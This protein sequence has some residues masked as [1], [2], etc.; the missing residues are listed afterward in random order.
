MHTLARCEQTPDG[1][2]SVRMLQRRARRQPTWILPGMVFSTPIESVSSA[3]VVFAIPQRLLREFRH[4][5]LP[6]DS[7]VRIL[8]VI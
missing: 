1:A 6:T 7:P 4:E 5:H 2:S 3:C 8:F